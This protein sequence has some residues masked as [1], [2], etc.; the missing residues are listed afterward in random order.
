MKQSPKE[1]QEQLPYKVRDKLMHHNDEDSDSS[2][3]SL[4]CGRN[5]SSHE[6]IAV[7]M[8]LTHTW[9]LFRVKVC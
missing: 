4:I 6:D 5:Y 3:S 1:E 7:Q 2:K 9:P 8:A